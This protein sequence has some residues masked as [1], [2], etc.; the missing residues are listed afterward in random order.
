M[1]GGL[2][3][4][5]GRHRASLPLVAGVDLEG[6]SEIAGERARAQGHELGPWEAPAGDEAIALRAVCR[7]CG[8]VA[9]V[10]AEGGMAGSAGDALTEGC[11]G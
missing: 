7:R 6:M 11:S 2:R 10:R 3:A 4:P 1:L 9:Y 8:R 5:D